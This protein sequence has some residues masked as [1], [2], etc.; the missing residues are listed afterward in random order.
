MAQEHVVLV[1]DDSE[2]ASVVQ[3]LLGGAGYEVTLSTSTFAVRS[4]VRERRPRVIIMDSDLPYRSGASFLTWL[5]AQPETASIPVL[6]MVHSWEEI[7]ARHRSLAAAILPKPIDGE[8]LLV[9]VQ[10]AAPLSAA[11]P[12]ARQ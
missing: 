9:D 6:M 11:R 12:A 4:L 1:V 10:A 2:L 3:H 8:A 7:P 5:K